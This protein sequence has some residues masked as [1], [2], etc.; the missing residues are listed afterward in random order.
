MSNLNSRPIKR[1]KC[2][3]APSLDLLKRIIGLIDLR[4]RSVTQL[5]R[6]IA[7]MADLL[8]RRCGFMGQQLDLLESVD[9]LITL[10]LE[11]IQ[12]SPSTRRFI[13]G[14]SFQG[15]DSGAGS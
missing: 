7:S 12:R 14:T 3:M 11:W 6:L 10:S 8:E 5:G 2:L 13:P 4:V 1:G 9:G 15:G